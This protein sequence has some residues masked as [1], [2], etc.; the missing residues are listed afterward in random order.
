[1]LWQLNYPDR[2]D[3]WSVGMVL[4]QV[5]VG[6]GSGG[7]P[8]HGVAAAGGGPQGTTGRGSQQSSQESG[9]RVSA[10]LEASS[11]DEE[12]LPVPAPL[13][14][15]S[16]QATPCPRSLCSWPSPACAATPAW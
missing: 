7:G 3:M 16:C 2:F 4:L 8:G 5:G 13:E 9:H 10:P 15:H 1:M 14:V 11:E 12:S 6:G